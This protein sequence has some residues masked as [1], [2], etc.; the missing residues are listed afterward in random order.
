MYII[1]IYMFSYRRR[2]E[3]QEE[4]EREYEDSLRQDQERVSSRQFKDSYIT[5]SLTIKVTIFV[6][7]S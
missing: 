1:T 5:L 3:E 6:V 4:Q 2:R 7:P